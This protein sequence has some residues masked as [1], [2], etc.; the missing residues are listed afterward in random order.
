[1]ME[2]TAPRGRA[3]L[4]DGELVRFLDGELASSERSVAEVHVAACGRCRT[5]HD[6]ILARSARVSSALALIDDL[7]AG[8]G[9]VATRPTAIRRASGAG[10]LRA[11]AIGALILAMGGLV[12]PTV[13]AWIADGWAA[14]RTSVSGSSEPAAD[15]GAQALGPGAARTRFVPRSGALLVR[16]EN[17][18]AAGTLTVETTGDGS[19]SVVFLSG[20]EEGILVLPAGLVIQNTPG[21]RADYRLLVPPDLTS[22]TAIAGTDTIAVLRPGSEGRRSWRIP[23]ADRGRRPGSSRSSP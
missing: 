15:P 23:L 17:P 19:G 20:S 2:R 16:L 4:E 18:P 22:V 8:D 1:M 12:S 14:F 13:R 10:W 21:S 6:R 9:S 3:H 11:A 5:A 7:G